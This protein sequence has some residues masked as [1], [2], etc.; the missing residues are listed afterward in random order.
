MVKDGY[1]CNHCLVNREGGGLFFKVAYVRSSVS[2]TQSGFLQAPDFAAVPRYRLHLR[3][4]IKRA[5]T[6]RFLSIKV[7]YKNHFKQGARTS[8][9]KTRNSIMIATR[10]ALPLLAAVIIS[11]MMNT[12]NAGPSGSPVPAG[13]PTEDREAL[14]CCNTTP[15]FIGC[16]VDGVFKECC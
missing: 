10:I 4:C 8:T 9:P 1:V 6:S 7:A 3:Q 15:C 14:T 16:P 13:N 11:V 2:F 12:V 5:A